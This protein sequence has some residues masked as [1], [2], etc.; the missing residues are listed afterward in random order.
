MSIRRGTTSLYTPKS[1]FGCSAFKTITEGHNS[2]LSEY[3]VEIRK[4]GVWKQVDSQPLSSSVR[5][6]V[7]IS[8]FSPIE[9]DAVRV[10]F[11]AQENI[12]SIA[13][14]GVY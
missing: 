9:A 2:R 11:K 10:R 6:R 7:H 4:D 14:I 13:E 1:S 3:A 8:H 12:L 5:S